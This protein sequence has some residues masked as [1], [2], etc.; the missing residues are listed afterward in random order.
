MKIL[1]I[2]LLVLSAL[3]ILLAACQNSTID[4]ENK[5][6]SKTLATGNFMQISSAVFSHQSTLPAKYTCDGDNISPPLSF[7]DLPTDA[8]SLVLIMDD[9]D[10]LKPAGRVWDHWLVWNIPPSVSQIAE[11]QNPSG[12]I[13]FN[14]EGRQ[15]YGGPCPPDGEHRYFFKLYALDAWLDLPLS[16]T[17]GEIEKAMAGHILDQ[18]ELLGLYNRN[19]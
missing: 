1:P 7:S 8:V 3:V 18:A 10:A 13:G 11:G 16:A 5:N 14:T 4:R 6:L 9:P 12:L 2:K 17:K 15:A 19:K